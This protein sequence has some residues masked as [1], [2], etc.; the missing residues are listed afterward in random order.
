MS[1]RIFIVKDLSSKKYAYC[2]SVEEVGGNQIFKHAYFLIK[3]VFRGKTYFFLLLTLTLCNSKSLSLALALEPEL[4]YKHLYLQLCLHLHFQMNF[5]LHMYFHCYLHYWQHKGT[6]IRPRKY[7]FFSLYVR[8]T[9]IS[10]THY[11]IT[12]PWLNELL[13]K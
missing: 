3:D 12:R 13:N 11:Q 4:L 5:H 9:V 7:D 2:A 10:Y 1:R 6:N 8:A